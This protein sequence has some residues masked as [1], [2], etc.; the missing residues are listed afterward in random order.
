MVGN[1]FL[2]WMIRRLFAPQTLVWGYRLM[3]YS[4]ILLSVLL[5]GK[6]SLW[7]ENGIDIDIGIDVYIGIDI[8]VFIFVI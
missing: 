6:S 8:G 4:L 1:P 5:C 3:Q 2:P 7:K